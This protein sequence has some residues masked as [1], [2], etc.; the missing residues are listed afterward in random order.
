[1]RVYKGIIITCDKDD[2]V[3]SYLVEDNGEILF[4][5]DELDDEYLE[6]EII[7]IGNRAIIPTFV[8]SHIHFASFATFH[9]G[10]NVMEA[11]SN[12]ELLM[13]LKEFVENTKDK[14]IIA[15]RASPHSV[16][17]KRLVTREEI[18]NVCKDKP[19]FLVKY[20]GHVCVLNSALLNKVKDKIKI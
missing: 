11:T 7:D 19:I 13:M 2:T 18:D 10:L 12:E 20:D 6:Y 9:F 3:T 1:M 4:V 17:E 8:D 14:T 15:F 16:K 5:G